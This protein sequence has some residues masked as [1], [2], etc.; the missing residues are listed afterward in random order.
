[1]DEKGALA[2]GPVSQLTTANG[3]TLDVETGPQEGRV[4]YKTPRARRGVP[5]NLFGYWFTAVKAPGRPP[6]YFAGYA[7]AHEGSAR[8]PLRAVYRADI[9]QYAGGEEAKLFNLNSN[10]ICAQTPQCH[11]LETGIAVVSADHLAKYSTEDGLV[12]VLTV[13]AGVDE[14]IRIPRDHLDAIAEAMNKP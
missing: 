4:V 13:S 11:T 3:V 9:S 5:Q 2:A 14:I 8:P 6:A 10:T 7:V 12:I 1:M